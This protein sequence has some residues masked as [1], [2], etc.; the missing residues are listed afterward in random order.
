MKIELL[1][2]DSMGVRSMATVVETKDLRLMIDPGVA[3][4]PY[5]YGLPPHELEI[6]KLNE[7][8]SIIEDNLIDCTHVV[9]THYHYDH[10]EPDSAELLAKKM[11]YVKHPTQ[12]INFSQKRRASYFLSKINEAGGTYQYADGRDI[13]VNSTIIR[14]SEPTPHGTNT[15]L[16]YV[17]MVSV[18][19]GE[20]KVLYTSDVEGPSL[21]AQLDIILRERSDVLIVDGPMTYMLGY[22]YSYES[23]EASIK[24]LVKI[25]RETPVKTIVLDHHLM[26]DL[27]YKQKIEPVIRE[28]ELKGVRLLSAAEFEG[29]PIEM[30][31]ARRKELYGSSCYKLD[32]T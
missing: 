14:I 11:V 31:E 9:I 29:K 3:L 7:M 25:I 26:R 20:E 23:L 16:G 30:L 6:K 2:Y 15:K 22:R 28:A 18:C 8:W 32:A 12:N 21:D 27:G 13:R 4:A 5:R 17:I 19:D 24:N 10:H 1:A